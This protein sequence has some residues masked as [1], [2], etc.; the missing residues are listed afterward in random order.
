[1]TA[2]AFSL[3]PISHRLSSLRNAIRGWILARLWAK[4]M[5]AVSIFIVATGLLDYMMRF[6]LAQRAILLLLGLGGLGYLLWRYL[7][8]PLS[9]PLRDEDLLARVEIRHP[10]TGESIL[11]AVEFSRIG[12]AAGLGLSERMMEA[13]IEL[14]L[15]KAE[16]TK[17]NDIVDSEARRRFIFQGATAAFCLFLAIAIT[18]IYAPDSFRTWFNR[19]VMLGGAEWPKRTE[20]ELVGYTGVIPRGDDWTQVVRAKGEVPSMVQIDFQPHSGSG[21]VTEVMRMVG[22]DEFTV[23]FRNIREP[24][25]FRVRGGDDVTRWYEIELAERPAFTELEL[26]VVPPDYILQSP[27]RTRQGRRPMAPNQ[28]AEFVYRG[29]S[30]EVSGVSNKPLV[31]A[32]VRHLGRDVAELEVVDHDGLPLRGV[33]GTIP[34]EVIQNGVFE[35]VLEDTTGLTTRRGDRFNI[36]L[37]RD[38]RPQ[39]NKQL[40]GI[41]NMVVPQATIPMVVEVI[42]DFAVM[43]VGLS[44]NITGGSLAPA[45]AEERARLAERRRREAADAGMDPVDEAAGEVAESGAA[46]VP[47]GREVDLPISVFDRFLG[48][49]RAGPELHRL[50]LIPL[51]LEVGQNIQFTVF[52]MDNDDVSGPNRGESSPVFLRVVSRDVLAQELLRREQEQRR[53]V[54]RVLEEHLN[55]LTDL[56]AMLADTARREAFL[57]DDRNVITRTERVQRL[58]GNRLRAV[59][60]QFQGIMQEHENNRMDE[61]GGLVRRRMN[62]RIIVPLR[63]MSINMTPAAA[64]ALEQAARAGETDQN[65]VELVVQANDLQRQIIDQ[66]REVMTYMERWEG[67]QELVNRLRALSEDQVRLRRQLQEAAD[68]EAESIFGD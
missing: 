67:Y 23:T 32:I 49:H 54:E 16:V 24:F 56:E 55:M 6:D 30:V 10:E 9:R 5:V 53:E 45:L 22:D 37:R 40:I 18:G 13:A 33:R 47:A 19:M 63:A 68:A 38:D 64:N 21:R 14:G 58:A 7:L 50:E 28:S 8:V 31:S 3:S 35:L 65:R 12:D 34:A 46:P 61:D 57:E 17:F 52:A 66:L 4:V 41:S 36:T 20:L 15:K 60:D 29:S 43:Q 59:A 39:I 51:D 1:M 27:E 48:Q 42:D 62:D 26:V 2:S 25:R 11:T 44:A